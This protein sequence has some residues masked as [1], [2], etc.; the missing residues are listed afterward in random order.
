MDEI[1]RG[2]STFD[3]LSLA[4]ATAEHLAR[5]TRSMTLFAT[6]YFELIQLP[7]EAPEVAN[8][9]LDAAEHHQGIVFLHAVKEGPANQSYGLE[10]AALAGVPKS[11]VKKA[12]EKLRALEAQTLQRP[13][14]PRQGQQLDLFRDMIKDPALLLLD[15]VDPEE[16][17]PREALDF[18]FEMK[19]KRG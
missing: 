12:R 11:V 19:A 16:M 9:H 6:H 10:V 1:G 2:T 13:V 14:E 18:L 3:G 5:V 4:F 17:T 7:E 15:A 8:V